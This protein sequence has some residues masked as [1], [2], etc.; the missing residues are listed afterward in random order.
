MQIVLLAVSLSM[1]S[2]FRAATPDDDLV[3]G[4]LLNDITA[5]EQALD[6]G[7]NINKHFK[8]GMTPLMYA[9]KQGKHYHGE[10][11]G[12]VVG[13]VTV[14]LKKS[15]TSMEVHTEKSHASVSAQTVG[16]NQAIVRLLIARGADINAED[17]AGR[18]A[19]SIA[20]QN[21]Q[22]AIITV[23]REAGAKE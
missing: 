16:G 7:A 8:D 19:L 17:S 12:D 3:S 10:A 23:L 18:T 20:I 1:A 4:I 11:G 15:E 13:T 22:A 5:V 9:C 14:N 2:C 21:N 6:R